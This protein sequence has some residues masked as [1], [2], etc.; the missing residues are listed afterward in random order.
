MIKMVSFAGMHH[1]QPKPGGCN[2]QCIHRRRHHHSADPSIQALWA[3]SVE[4]DVVAYTR[5]LAQNSVWHVTQHA[6]CMEACMGANAT[7][8]AFGQG[9][10][11][12]MHRWLGGHG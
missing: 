2:K 4:L 9:K 5:V 7:A 12:M 10:T 1:L 6:W 11:P 8:H 3:G